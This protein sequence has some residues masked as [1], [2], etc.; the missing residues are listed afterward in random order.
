VKEGNPLRVVGLGLGEPS[1]DRGKVVLRSGVEERRDA[2]L[3]ACMEQIGEEGRACG[4]HGA[5][6]QTRMEPVA[7][8]EQIGEQG[9]SCGMHGANKHGK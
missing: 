3:V 4:M 5:N 9:E 2:E 7:C 8:M 6:R 1:D